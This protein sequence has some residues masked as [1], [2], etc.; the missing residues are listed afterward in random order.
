MTR[1]AF[2]FVLLFLLAF[3]SF[4]GAEPP[5]VYLRITDSLTIDPGKIEDFYSQELVFNVFE[6]LVRLRRDRMQAE[7]CLAERWLSRENGRHW[8]FYLRRGVVFHNGEA[9][10]AKAV[11]YTF[12][13]RI[14]KRSGEYAYFGRIFPYVLDVRA[15]DDWTVEFQLSRP[16]TPFPLALVDQ[17]ASIVAP[18]SLEGEQFKAI[19]TGPFVLS[20]WV[21]GKAIVLS[22]FERYWG[23]P[24]RLAKI[25]FKCEPNAASR[26]SQIKNHSADVDLIRSAKEH[27][28]LLGHT[29]IEIVSAPVV[30]TE[31]LGFNCRRPPFSSPLA[32]K[33]FFHL[34]NRTVLVK[35]IFQN[36]ALP[37]TS[38]MPPMMMGF[39]AGIGRDD[40]SLEK[41]QRLLRQAGLG[42]G[43]ACNL[44]FADG[45]FGLED[46]ART[47][48]ANARLIRITVKSVKLPFAML[49]Q[50]EQ[51]GEADMF[52]VGWGYTGDPGVFLN[53]MFML[54]PG[55]RGRVMSAGPE[56]SRLLAQAEETVDDA[57]RG[58]IY[59]DA[60][61]RLQEDMPLIPLYYLNHVVAYSKRLQNLRLNPFGFLI[62]KDA[63]LAAN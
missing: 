18:G 52:L 49:L 22:R 53:P 4:G 51:G 61:R 50:A 62:F 5:V 17:R 44:Y 1:K 34:L 7:P 20:E 25:V 8:I 10:T 16:Y 24:A 21:R 32:R 39:N 57:Q 26:L 12:K 46:L 3:V 37:A 47:I 40:F 29:D 19:G 56:F 2:G 36:F 9:F 41:A 14:A 27:E 6:G 42:N 54:D 28:E 33:A 45:Q 35:Q 31:F 48:A 43:F 30:A 59:D 63:I 15:L 11:V 55:G 13:K 38:M 23:R 60:Q 58:R